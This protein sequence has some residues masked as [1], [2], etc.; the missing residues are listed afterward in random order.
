MKVF[1]LKRL[2]FYTVKK[3]QF[4]FQL[5]TEP[6]KK[7]KIFPMKKNVV[8][9]KRKLCTLFLFFFWK[10]LLRKIANTLVLKNLRYFKHIYSSAQK[11]TVYS[12]DGLENWWYMWNCKLSLYWLCVLLPK[13]ADPKN[14][15]KTDTI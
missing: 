2:R 14:A 1:A 7:P 4:F 13:H 8:W 5:S 3:R 6:S 11:Y 9:R 10:I 12:A 15:W